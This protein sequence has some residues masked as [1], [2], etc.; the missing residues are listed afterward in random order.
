MASSFN[1]KSSSSASSAQ[2][3]GAAKP[4]FR[5][6]QGKVVVRSVQRAGADASAEEPPQEQLL[7]ANAGKVVRTTEAQRMDAANRMDAARAVQGTAPVARTKALVSQGAGKH[8]AQ[9]IKV[10]AVNGKTLAQQPKKAAQGGEAARRAEP[11]APQDT[12]SWQMPDTPGQQTPQFRPKKKQRAPQGQKALSQAAAAPKVTGVF[13]RILAAVSGFFDKVLAFFKNLMSR[14]R[15]QAAQQAGKHVNSGVLIGVL[16]GLVTLMV[17]A[18]LVVNSGLF[19]ATDIQV[20]GSVHMPAE[21]V[22]QLLKV[23]DSTTL[24][25]V[26]EDD[27]AQSLKDN[28]WVSGVSV[29]KRFP[30][31]LVVTPVEKTASVIVYMNTD[32]VAWAVGTDHTWIAPIATA[33]V[34][35]ADGNYVADG[36]EAASDQQA[37]TGTEALL[38][39]ARSLG[40][41]L[42]INAPSDIKPV[43][44][45]EVASE[46]IL[47]GLAYK[48]GFS[49]EFV[50]SIKDM[51]VASLEALSANLESGVE[52]SLG[53][54]EDIERK[55]KV[56]T[57]L[58]EEQEGV[59]YINVRDPESYTFRAAPSSN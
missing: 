5:K 16:V 42:L 23:G 6:A 33:V 12:S 27:L 41:L 55:E 35:D 32:D 8:A 34:A 37:L 29:E 22:Q 4:T 36:S 30:H 13:P 57:K 15:T 49:Q 21:S 28:P 52:V 25:N 53:P 39:Q 50:N 19:A 59:T 44:G 54:A 2:G 18:V 58:L 1:Q 9:K 38:A 31:T 3:A 11:S 45:E 48:E 7:R 10:K 56:I 43:S 20:R 40:A 46:L 17:A 47:A 26:N 51:S 14:D 24:L